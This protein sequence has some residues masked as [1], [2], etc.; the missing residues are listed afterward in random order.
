VIDLEAIVETGDGTRFDKVTALVI[1]AVAI[2]AALL[3]AVQIDL[4]QKESRAAALAARYSVQIFQG[5]NGN[6]A[7]TS[8][9][10]QAA[11]DAL[12]VSIG[13]LNRT[14]VVLE[15]GGDGG[16]VADARMKPDLA[17]SERLQAI[18]TEM[19]AVPGPG[20]QLD[21]LARRVTSIELTELGDL[22]LLQNAQVDLAEEYGARGGRAVLGLSLVALAG[23]LLGLGAVL[24]EGPAGR[25]ALG[26]AVIA[27]GAAAVA[28][29][30]A[31]V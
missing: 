27:A 18:A 11:Q 28:A 1:G 22:A 31:L 14:L 21:A 7:R 3:G 2:L 13:A 17:A 25:F 8:F 15:Q 29:V 16:D 4:S 23:V 10:L 6:S 19:G 26:A 9:E 20:V 12:T 5:I 24:G 30:S